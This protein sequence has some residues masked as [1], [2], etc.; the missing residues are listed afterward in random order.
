MCILKTARFYQ[1]L[2]CVF[3]NRVFKSHVLKSLFI[4]TPNSINN[5]DFDK[6]I[7]SSVD[8]CKGST[9]NQNFINH[10]FNMNDRT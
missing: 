4:Y 2:Y 5:L 9:C 7:R 3:K 1:M 6:H 8:L 10:L